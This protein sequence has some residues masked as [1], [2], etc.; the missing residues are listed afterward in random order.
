MRALSKIQKII[1]LFPQLLK[2][3]VELNSERSNVRLFKVSVI[4]PSMNEKSII[5][6]FFVLSSLL[7]SSHHLSLRFSGANDQLDSNNIKKM[8]KNL[9]N[10]SEK[11]SDK[12]LCFSF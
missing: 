5:N 8:R 12:I 7:L 3:V 1:F 4:I 10:E 2:S 9:R 6:I 11:K